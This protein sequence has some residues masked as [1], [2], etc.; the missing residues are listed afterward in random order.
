MCQSEISELVGKHYDEAAF[1]TELDRLPLASPVEMHITLRF[2]ARYVPDGAR[3]C[4]I[5][6][7][8]GIYSLALARRRCTLHFVDVSRRLLDYVVRRVREEGLEAQIVGSTYASATASEPA[9]LGG[10][11]SGGAFSK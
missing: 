8:G 3:V 5:G 11:G 9:D 6:V 10:A 7:G 1:Q 2:L 4:E